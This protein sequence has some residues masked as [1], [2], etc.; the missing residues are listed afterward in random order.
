MFSTPPNPQEVVSIQRTLLLAL[1]KQPTLDT[2]VASLRQKYGMELASTRCCDVMA[3]AYDEQGQ[4]ANPQGP[5]NWNPADCGGGQ[6]GVSGGQTPPG[7]LEV[8]YVLGPVPLAQQLPALT[9]NLCN[10]NVYVTAQLQR[11]EA[12]KGVPV[13]HQIAVFLGERPL[14][15]RNAVAGQQYLDG[16]AA[17]KQQQQQKK[18]EQQK[19]PTL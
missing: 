13:V 11:G 8:D 19:A 16:L 6:L 5:S 18:A 10:R 2:T 15:L 17:A 1:D 7:S 3:W 12:I 9:G 4:P 14:M